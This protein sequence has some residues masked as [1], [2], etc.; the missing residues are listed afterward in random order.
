M[1][2]K[3]QTSFM[4]K[5]KPFVTDMNFSL[6]IAIVLL[7]IFWSIQSPYFFTLY[8]ITNMGFAGSVT[9]IMA[10]GLTISLVMGAFDL[11]QYAAG[12]LA[13][14]V[15][16]TLMLNGAPVWVGFIVAIIVGVC[17]GVINGIILT[18]FKINPFITTLGTQLIFRALCYI[19]TSSQTLYISDP[20]MEFIGQGYLLGLPTSV[21]LMVVVYLV[22]AYVVKYTS[23]G[24]SVFAVGANANAS[25]LAGININR[26]RILG[27][28]I[29]STCAAIAG[30]LVTAQ[31]GACLPQNGVGSEMNITTAVLLGGLKLG[32]GK[33]KLSGTFLGLLMI[34]IIDNGLT[35]LSVESYYQMLVRGCILVL[36]VLIDSV[37][38]GGYK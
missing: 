1:E 12:T 6:S 26:V 2:L 13:A 10:A 3:K 21:W 16:T 7:C 29:S 14:V 9:G 11:S 20:V 17:C 33:A 19:I 31:L 28:V 38:G 23:F 5:L 22:L 27:F 25:F 32:G 35:L 18:V 30:F 36:A 37:R 15:A 4:Q 8:N 34:T 24:R